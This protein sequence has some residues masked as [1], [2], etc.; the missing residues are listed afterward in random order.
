MTAP[1]IYL[2]ALKR[3]L[4]LK[5]FGDALGVAPPRA[6]PPDFAEKLRRNKREILDFLEARATG[7]T[8]DCV[9]W[10]HVARQ[11]QA[12][13]FDEADRSTVESLIIGV[14]GIRHPLCQQALARLQGRS[15]NSL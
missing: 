1:E 3:G 8:A 2:E 7:L 4:R 9:P 14:R 12:G 10:L 6:C 5:A 15:P 13:E 11:I